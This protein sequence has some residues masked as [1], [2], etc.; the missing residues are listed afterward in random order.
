MNEPTK[1]SGKYRS[2]AMTALH[3]AASDL[4][5]IG[6]LDELTMR[7][8]DSLCLTVAKEHGAPASRQSTKQSTI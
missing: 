1:K 7:S 8:F 4:Y 2:K 5:K 3:E 6:G